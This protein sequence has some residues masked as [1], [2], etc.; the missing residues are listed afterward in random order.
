[1]WVE[2]ENPDLSWVIIYKKYHGIN[3]WLLIPKIMERKSS[4]EYSST[5]LPGNTR[6]KS[7]KKSM[8]LTSDIQ[9]KYYN[10]PLPSNIKTI[11]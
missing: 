5:P 9:Q 2:R 4:D 11:G 6:P 1:M 3:L 10:P 8:H 7:E